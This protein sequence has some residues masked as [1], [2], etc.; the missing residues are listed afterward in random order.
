M[1]VRM[2]L[3]QGFGH[4]PV[5]ET[6]ARSAQFGV[7][8]IAQPVVAE[9]VG[10][11]ALFLDDTPLPEFFQAQHH[12]IFAARA[13]RR[14]QLIAKGASDHGRQ[15]GHFLSGGRKLAKARPDHGVDIG[16]QQGNGLVGGQ[17]MAHA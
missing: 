9:V 3:L 14:Q 7:G 15:A 6:P 8:D 2:E 11:A 1:A 16:R 17:C 13:G 12:F 10:I 5:Q 4:A